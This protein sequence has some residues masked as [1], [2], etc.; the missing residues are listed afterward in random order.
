ME[1]ALP[2]GIGYTFVLR[3]TF[4]FKIELLQYVSNF[5]SSHKVPNHSTLLFSSHLSDKIHHHS[6]VLKSLDSFKFYLSLIFV[7]NFDTKEEYNLE[8]ND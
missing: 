2:G 7:D 1:L 8:M 5:E 3:F 4:F 6:T